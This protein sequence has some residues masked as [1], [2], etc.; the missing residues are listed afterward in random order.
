[1]RKKQERKKLVILVGGA[2][3]ST[4]KTTF[5]KILLRT[6]PKAFAVLKITP[7]THYGEGI[8]EDP[9][10]LNEP[11]KDTSSFLQEETLGV[12]WIRGRRENVPFLT[13]SLLSKLHH[14]IIV[15]GN[16]FFNFRIPDIVFFVER[17]NEEI[18]EGS[19]LLKSNADYIVKNTLKISRYSFDGKIFAVNLKEAL[20]NKLPISDDIHKI[21]DSIITR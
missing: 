1:M 10:I 5:I 3:S 13:D 16:I 8:V 4:G 18:K 7:N 21:L 19:L 9:V 20:K 15:E 12:F 6:F 17:E 14:N 2:K 11:G